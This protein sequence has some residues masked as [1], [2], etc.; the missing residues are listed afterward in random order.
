MC[1]S[2]KG[3][4]AVKFKKAFAA[5][6]IFALL[7]LAACGQGGGEAASSDIGE[8]SDD[9]PVYSLPFNPYPSACEYSSEASACSDASVVTSAA[10]TCDFGG[11]SVTLPSGFTPQPADDFEM[12]AVDEEN[13]SGVSLSVASFNDLYAQGL[14]VGMSAKEY[15]QKVVAGEKIKAVVLDRGEAA[16]FERTVETESGQYRYFAY[17]YKGGTAFYMLQFFCPEEDAEACR[18]YFD[19]I[20][21]T[22]VIKA[23]Y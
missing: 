20:A 14:D 5:C 17:V 9:M 18:S 15:A 16:Y 11:F 6:L 7:P 22:V 19:D 2:G 3:I 4:D 23:G 10:E 8:S 1:P 21:D 13:F 12:Y